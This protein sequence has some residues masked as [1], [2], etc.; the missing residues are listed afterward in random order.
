MNIKELEEKNLN[1]VLNEEGLKSIQ[2]GSHLANSMEYGQRHRR[3]LLEVES[4]LDKNWFVGNV[5]RL[6]A[7]NHLLSMGKNSFLIRNNTNLPGTL[8][9]TL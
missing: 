6:E 8:N 7:E 4:E 9:K 1:S 3:T 5:S 2:N